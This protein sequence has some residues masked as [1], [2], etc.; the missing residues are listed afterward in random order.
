MITIFSDDTALELRTLIQH[1]SE[2][3]ALLSE[4]SPFMLSSREIINGCIMLAKELDNHNDLTYWMKPENNARVK[5]FLLN[6]IGKRFF[7]TDLP[8]LQ[9]ALSLKRFV[10]Y[11]SEQSSSPK[12]SIKTL[13]KLTRKTLPNTLKMLDFHL[14]LMISIYTNKEQTSIELNSIADIQKTLE[15]DHASSLHEKLSRHRCFSVSLWQN[16]RGG[17][18]LG[19][20][21]KPQSSLL[22]SLSENRGPQNAHPS[23]LLLQ[24]KES[25][26]TKPEF[27]EK[28]TAL[29]E[30]FIPSLK[31]CLEA[32]AIVLSVHKGKKSIINTLLKEI[33]R[34]KEEPVDR[35]LEILSIASHQAHLNHAYLC[36]EQNLNPGRLGHVIIDLINGVNELIQSLSFSSQAQL[37]DIRPPTGAPGP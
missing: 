4:E 3:T 23:I 22:K 14:N 17:E 36:C 12:I 1:L 35:Q 13:S 9:L 29:T 37:T 21:L 26:E 16:I 32:R 8:T 11:I 5:S 19:R 15:R 31:V 25:P 6:D 33:E 28:L 34:A 18:V 20:A 27:K 24:Q 30:H 7:V 10:E 2:A